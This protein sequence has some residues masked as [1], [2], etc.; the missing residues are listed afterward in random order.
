MQ[1]RTFCLVFTI[2]FIS[3]TNNPII[4]QDI[5]KY[6]G[7]QKFEKTNNVWYVIDKHTN[8]KYKVNQ[9][10]LTIKLKEGA[11]RD[12][13]LELNKKYE[14]KIELENILGYIDLILPDEA[15]CFEL[16]SIYENS[17][18]F[19]CIE[20]NSFGKTL[21]SDTYFNNQ[22]YLDNTPHPTRPD[23]N[24]TEARPMTNTY[25]DG[26]VIAIIDEGVYLDHPDLVAN[27]N[28][29]EGWV[30]LTQLETI[31]NHQL[32]VLRIMEH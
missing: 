25:G 13:L 8:E 3:L 10:S 14:V 26:I 2:L 17:G 20:I 15:D 23:I 32:T 21:T 30:S 7:N 29:N 24:F 5:T 31:H 19:E 18:L 22:Y 11:S 12:N 28:S 1:K 9:T 6:L 16:Y 27:K 4:S